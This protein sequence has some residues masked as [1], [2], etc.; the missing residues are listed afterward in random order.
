MYLSVR[1]FS[2]Y[3]R[4]QRQYEAVTA[5]ARKLSDD[6][7]NLTG[8]H[9]RIYDSSINLKSPQWSIDAIRDKMP[10]DKLGKK[11]YLGTLSV[12]ERHFVS[13]PYD[14]EAKLVELGV[15]LVSHQP[16]KPRYTAD[17][18]IRATIQI[19]TVPHFRKITSILNKKYGHG[20]WHFRNCK[21]ILQK[22]R[23]MEAAA[24]GKSASGF[25]FQ[26]QTLRAP[27]ESKNGLKVDVVVVN[28]TDNSENL[29]RYLFQAQL[30]S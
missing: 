9:S 17:Q 2:F 28:T 14:I 27:D 10:K 3:Y 24:S 23:K 7:S 12:P 18:L 29:Q 20:N 4:N 13:I 6:V 26:P 22:L 1:K 30:M 19:K 8:G 21:K 16:N 15:E 11:K 25:H 5:F